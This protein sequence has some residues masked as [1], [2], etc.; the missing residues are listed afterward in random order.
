[1]VTPFAS[2][3]AYAIFA[4]FFCLAL[5][6]ISLWLRRRGASGRLIGGAW[7][8]LVCT[9]IPGWFLMQ[10]S[11]NHERKRLEDAILGMAP[12]YASEL[13]ALGHHRIGL[14]TAPD[15]PLYLAMI[16][17]QKSWLDLNPTIADI[18]TFR[19]DGQ[20]PDKNLLIVDSETDYDGNGEIDTSD[21]SVEVRSR[22]GEAWEEGGDLLRRAYEGE[23][24]FDGD[25]YTD[26]WG[27]WVSA[28]VPMRHPVTG[29]VDAV[30]G[31]DFSAA[32]WGDA[33]FRAR[34]LALG[35]LAVFL[36]SVLG[37]VT[38]IA[39]LRS[40]LRER[41]RAAKRTRAIIDQAH[42]AFVVMDEAGR[43][44]DWN[45]QSTK[46]FGWSREEAIGRDVAELLLPEPYRA[47]HRRGVQRFLETGERRLF[48]N[49]MDITGVHK[50]G[51]EIPIEMTISVVRDGDRHRFHAFLH[52]ST[53][54]VAK[55]TQ[56]RRAKEDAEAATR[57][58]SEFIASVSHEIRTPL[59]GILGMGELLGTTALDERQQRYLSQ[60]QQ[61]S[62]TL[63]H[64]LN[65]VLDMSK[66]EAGRIELEI[67]PFDLRATL[68]AV[69]HSIR[70]RAEQKGLRM[71]ARIASDVPQVL[72]GDPARLAQV[73]A[74]LLGNAIKFTREGS[75]EVVADVA[76]RQGDDL[77]LS[78]AVTD[79]GI[80]IP[81]DRQQVIFEAFRQEDASTTRR[82]GGTGLGLSICRHLVTCMGGT[83]EVKSI[84]QRGSTFRFTARFQVGTRADLDD[85]LH[86]PARETPDAAAR[87]GGLRIL[88]AEDG[89]VN[90]QVAVGLLE[91]DGHVV[92]VVEDG[93]QAVA[94]V[95]R[96]RYDVVLMDLL[97]PVMDGLDATRVIRDLEGPEGPH[98]PIVALTAIAMHGDRERCL[99]AGM[100]GYLSKPIDR[101]ELQATL[102]AVVEAGRGE[103]EPAP[104]M[105][106]HTEAAAPS[107]VPA[108]ATLV[109]WRLAMRRIPG[110]EAGIRELATL[111]TSEGPRLLAEMRR[112][113]A[114]EA[115]EALRQAAHT[116]R[117]SVHHFGGT[118]LVRAAQEI[119]EAARAGDL[120][121]TDEPLARLETLVAA[122][123]TELAAASTAELTTLVQAA[124]EPGRAAAPGGADDA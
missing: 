117:G 76:E 60:L 103:E 77:L 27:T 20:T 43:I 13:A 47:E 44:T 19:R 67:R 79:T 41:Q 6:G 52:D 26:Y 22:I 96:G 23:V 51:H 69:V 109:D 85:G 121:A 14:Q 9:L 37:L 97:M 116:L 107:E 83:I 49:R 50:D 38:V 32:E 15:D 62:E 95:R 30:L 2:E 58:K 61:S 70:P 100:N 78:V 87:V 56:L 57:V 24:V 102:R 10:A 71:E 8:F 93:K 45:P 124:R 80:G 75:I 105:D 7:V 64:L 84:V 1:M 110:G 115:T 104:A 90:Q 53:D 113:R 35:V 111:M 31:V 94:A 92:D 81:P 120:P 11:E 18:Y 89:K 106:A 91:L 40:N 21:D 12:T 63:L 99:R 114:A 55:E 33:L 101:S 119:E 86:E 74:N 39:V 82:Y 123:G 68:E 73:L 34:W 54:R 36:V 65:D 28:Y 5:G 118:P 108:P 17:K 46:V 48:E 98:V 66:V 88:L 112:A 25:P 122:F 3:I 16:E 42:D 72:H 4:G 59:N 29:A